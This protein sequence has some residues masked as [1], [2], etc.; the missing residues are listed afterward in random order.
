MKKRKNKRKDS[1]NLSD[2]KTTRS[3]IMGENSEKNV[4]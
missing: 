3:D 4:Q 1:E 2:I